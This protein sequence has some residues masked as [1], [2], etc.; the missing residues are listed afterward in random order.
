MAN[1]TLNVIMNTK[2]TGTGEKDLNTGLS[3][4]KKGLGD[5]L[6]GLTGFSMAS[7]GAAGAAA[8]IAGGLKKAVGEALEAE[9]V[10]A[11]TEA[12]I[13]STGGAAGMS[14]EEISRLAESQSRLT[15]IDDETIQ[16]GMNML[17]TFK[18]IGEE[19]F[20]RASQAMEDMAV[21]MAK[22][23][24][25]AI[26]LQG[27][28]IQLGK[29][30]N[31]PIMG[32]STLKRVGVQLS[33]EQQ[34]AVRDFMEVNDVASAQ[35]IILGELESQFG[36]M[37]ETMGNTAGGKI[38]K[39]KN[40]L[41]N[42]FEEIGSVFLPILGDAADTLSLLLNYGS[43]VNEQYEKHREEIIYTSDSY[44]GYLDE[45]EKASNLVGE[46]Y[47]DNILLTDGITDLGTKEEWLVEQQGALTEEVW[48]YVRATDNGKTETVD[49]TEQM[50][51]LAAATEEVAD[52][53]IGED[54]YARILSGSMD[55]LTKKELFNAAAKNLDSES[56]LALANEMGLLDD[57]SR[58]YLTQLEYLN[59]QLKEEKITADEYAERIK[60]M[61]EE[62]D[63]QN[64]KH[65]DL[66]VIL[67]G[68]DEFWRL[69]SAT[70]T[71]SKNPLGM[72]LQ[73]IAQAEG[74]DWFV[75][76]PTLFL[77]G[78][79]GPERATFTPMGGG[80]AAPAGGGVVINWQGSVRSEMDIE[81]IARRLAEMMQRR[82]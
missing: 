57:K 6:Q 23:D 42:L 59:K 11:A 34:K 30:L 62:I 48:N 17:L 33:E 26:D 63:A 28:A 2:K 10:M 56:A 9:R 41:N 35:A 61:G 40:A 66:K 77:A 71:W 82:M 80:G 25:S 19:T 38:Q 43:M 29:A 32:V 74:G 76:R 81:M 20:P 54:G 44:E 47:E 75:T 7:L 69:W 27:A 68:A 60:E 14:A 1:T 8:L 51:L 58:A 21:A 53:L 4:M 24:T 36:G 37:A 79:A 46:S 5:V 70:Q 18:S 12:V 67:E 55:E 45:L 15:S 31:D 50:H 64:G 39:A 65:L 52:A 13:Q 49:M 72:N 78:E 73:P 3:G 22:G 16:S